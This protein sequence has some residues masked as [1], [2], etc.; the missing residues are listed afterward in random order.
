M[1]RKPIFTLNLATF[2][3]SLGY[4]LVIPVMPFYME[5]L[6]AGGRKLGW[7]TAVYA[8]A[9]T[10]S[11][12]M[13]GG[14]SDRIGRKPVIGVGMLGYAVSLLLFGLATSFRTLFL[15]RCFSGILSSATA[16][17]SMAYI[18]DSVSAE[19]R[20]KNMGQVGAAMSTGTVVGPLIGGTLSGISIALPFFVGAAVSFAAFILILTILPESLAEKT[21]GRRGRN[22]ARRSYRGMLGGQ[23]RFILSL[24][25][26]A[27]FCQTG[28]QGITGLYVVDKFSLSSAQVGVVWMSLAAVLVIAQGVLVGRLAG[29]VP[30]KL[31]IAAGLGGGAVCLLAVTMTRGFGSIMVVLCLFALTAALTVPTL[32][33]GLANTAG[34]NKGA[35]MGLASTVRSLSKVVGPLLFGYLYEMKMELPYIGGSIAALTGVV[36][37]VYWMKRDPYSSGQNGQKEAIDS[38]G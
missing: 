17:A 3:V 25:F 4:G 10:V 9:Q 12:P 34:I 1:N 33:A 14:L 2:V 19:E 24:I 36:L 26:I 11:A 23:V 21:G 20:S 28:L 27:S 6:G 29:L 15:A 31:L 16:A 35:L 5:S 22:V 32:N 13:W 8:L 18:G 7:L 37:C 30:E 38:S